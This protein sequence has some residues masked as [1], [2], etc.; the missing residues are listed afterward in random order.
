MTHLERDLPERLKVVRI[1]DREVDLLEEVRI[2]HDG[3][4]RTLLEEHPE[5]VAAWGR[6]VASLRSKVARV[7]DELREL[8]GTVGVA[9]WQGME[10]EERKEMTQTL[11]DEQEVT[12]D[13]FHPGRRQKRAD[14]RIA[15]GFTAARWHRNFSDELVRW[16]VSSDPK[17]M[18]KRA[19]VRRLRSELDQAM[20]VVTA[21]EHRRTSLQHLV[22]L[23]RDDRGR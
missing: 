6:A 23:Y 7:R 2:P 4:Y 20:S 19:E 14:L 9:Y 3:D 22:A 5:R 11:H 16:H 13:A 10:D 15:K 21:L 18:E 17:V 12:R 1:L 8:E